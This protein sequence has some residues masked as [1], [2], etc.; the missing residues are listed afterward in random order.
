ML[1]LAYLAISVYTADRLSHP[2]R[3][4]LLGSPAQA[5]LTYEDVE[6]PSAGDHIRLSGWLLNAPSR[7]VIVMLHG[8]DQTR[9]RDEA[10][11]TK[12]GLLVR[13]GYAVLMF[14]F[15]A[16]GLSGGER[17]AMGAWETRDVAGA[18]AYLQSR[19]Y[20]TF[21]VYGVSMGA[22]T[23]LLTAPEHPEIGALFLDSPY[24][25]LPALLEKRLPEVS[26][27]PAFFTPGLFSMGRLMFGMDFTAV[28]PADALARLGTRPVYLVQSRDGDSE[29]PVT[30]GLA[31][32]QAGA[33]NPNFTFWRAP[34]AGHVHSYSNNPAEY[35][36]RLLAFY[37]RYLP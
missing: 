2:A 3:Q 23:G 34:G 24:A 17:Y 32:A 28:K 36:Q 9:D 19:G 8:R 35:T 11:L 16:H 33:A 22:A 12:A 13:E 27:L 37:A 4:T 29:V 7:R 30:E 31:L 18:L 10:Y 14:D 20:Q 1:L 25:D 26:G 6:F 21:G 5:G 15:R